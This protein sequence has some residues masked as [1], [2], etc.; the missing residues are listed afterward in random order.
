MLANVLVVDQTEEFG[1]LIRS[2]LEES[3]QYQVSLAMNADEAIA[4]GEEGGLHL[5][6]IDFDLTDFD[7]PSFIQRIRSVNPGIGIIAI[8]PNNNPNDPILANLKIDGVLTKPFYLPELNR[9]VAEAIQQPVHVE[10]NISS[11]DFNPQ[12][13][14]LAWVS[15]TSAPWANDTHEASQRLSRI[16]QAISA[17]ALILLYLGRPWSQAGDITPSQAEEVAAKITT[18]GIGEGS[19]GAITTVTH[20]EGMQRD[21]TLYA[22]SLLDDWILAMIYPSGTSFSVIRRQAQTAADRLK[23]FDA[24][25][26]DEEPLPE[27]SPVSETAPISPPDQAFE[28]RDS[29]TDSEPEIQEMP[30]LGDLDLPS[31]EPEGDAPPPPDIQPEVVKTPVSIPSDW[32]PD[33]PMPESHLPFLE[34]RTSTPAVSTSAAQDHIP[35]PDAEY[36]L[37]V[38]AVL[39]PR[40][41]EQQLVGALAENLQEW[42]VR[43]CLAWDWRADDVTIDPDYL[44]LTMSISPET[45]PSIAIERLRDDLSQRILSAFPE[46]V[47]NLPSRRFW[48]RSY[49]LITGGPPPSERVLAFVQSTRKG[50]GIEN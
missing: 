19:R 35:L 22:N 48:A 42:V 21:C 4:I 3:G 20:I 32:V 39:V 26:Y 34:G 43:L 36:Y 50:Q 46:F 14:A 10:S 49:L 6:I 25:S 8:P 15:G 7:A 31:P 2:T 23:N 16:C 37:P 47:E 17:D 27:I 38:T 9:I 11:D 45:A 18:I 28:D 24:Y 12:E 44:C 41:P 30:F 13:E 33:K 40:F 1:A 5:L 29:Y